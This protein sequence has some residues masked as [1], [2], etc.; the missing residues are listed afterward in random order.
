MP[1]NPGRHGFP[2]AP[3]LLE[4]KAPDPDDH[5]RTAPSFFLR[6]G[7]PEFLRSPGSS[8]PVLQ[9]RHGEPRGRSRNLASTPGFPSSPAHVVPGSFSPRFIQGFL[10][11]TG[12]PFPSGKMHRR[13]LSSVELPSR[14]WLTAQLGCLCLKDSSDANIMQ[15]WNKHRLPRVFKHIQIF[16]IFMPCLCGFCLHPHPPA[17]A[18]FL[19]IRGRFKTKGTCFSSALVTWRQKEARCSNNTPTT[20]C[21]TLDVFG[22][23][24]ILE[25]R[26]TVIFFTGLRGSYTD[27]S[28]FQI[29]S[30]LAL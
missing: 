14:L 22:S 1:V 16:V 12:L 4:I 19:P 20:N 24:S 30:L 17:W 10:E 27:I 21:L 25:E 3:Y 6:R 29:K 23:F 5:D 7:L 26:K 15:K 9:R 11:E 28:E 8:L 18:P 2:F 13:W